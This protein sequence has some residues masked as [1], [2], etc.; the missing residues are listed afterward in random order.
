[1]YIDFLDIQKK[2]YSES[3]YVNSSE[4]VLIFLF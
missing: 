3:F 4:R 2:I 1:M